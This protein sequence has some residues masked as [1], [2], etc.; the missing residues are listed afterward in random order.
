MESE[1]R[2]LSAPSWSVFTPEDAMARLRD[3]GH[4]VGPEPSPTMV[5]G[6]RECAAFVA[7]WMKNRGLAL[8]LSRCEILAGSEGEY[9]LDVP[10][11]PMVDLDLEVDYL[12]EP[13]SG[14]TLLNAQKGVLYRR[15]AFP[16][17]AE[18]EPVGLFG[19][20]EVLGEPHPHIT[21]RFWAGYEQG[22]VPN[23]L[24][25][26]IWITFKAW[27]ERIPREADTAY[28]QRTKT[29]T[30]YRKPQALPEEAKEILTEYHRGFRDG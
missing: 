9:R 7:T 4:K 24:I 15:D 20:M 3:A 17:T 22:K 19:I 11:R 25:Q 1:I 12:G 23:E 2:I 8:G 29:A 27:Y 13:L 18:S 28:E 14:V 10:F 26:A 6:A 16:C 30:S 5:F 21:V